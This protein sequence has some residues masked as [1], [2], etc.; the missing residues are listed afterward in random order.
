M[1]QNAGELCGIT[2]QIPNAH[3]LRGRRIRISGVFG[4]ETA[5][6]T[7]DPL[8]GISIWLKGGKQTIS[9]TVAGD[10]IAGGIGYDQL[11]FSTALDVKHVV[12]LLP[13]NA[14][15]YGTE[16]DRLN[17]WFDHIEDDGV[18]LFVEFTGHSS[19]GVVARD[20]MTMWYLDDQFSGVPATDGSF[21]LHTEVHNVDADTKYFEAYIDVP[22]DANL[23]EDDECWIVVMGVDPASVGSTVNPHRTHLYGL[24]VEVVLDS[25]SLPDRVLHG[26]LAHQMNQTPWGSG[27]LSPRQLYRYP[28][29]VPGMVALQVS[30]LV[31]AATGVGAP[32]AGNEPTIRRVLTTGSPQDLYV[33][34]DASLGVTPWY[35]IA[36]QAAL[37][38][39]SCVVKAGLPIAHKSGTGGY[40]DPRLM[41]S[42]SYIVNASGTTTYQDRTHKVVDILPGSSSA[43]LGDYVLREATSLRNRMGIFWPDTS[44]GTYSGE[45]FVDGKQGASE[46]F[47]VVE[48]DDTGDEVQL[49]TGYIYYVYDPRTIGLGGFDL[50][51]S[52]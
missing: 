26:N 46:L 41:Q 33:A 48:V 9:S 52:P 18:D 25:A 44:T 3:M 14:T 1:T 2:Q 34:I 42:N 24:A 28:F 22:D 4:T 37:P 8:G 50:S 6:A 43:P 38:P 5:P 30:S 10:W 47:F 15:A 51:G 21:E 16:H 31:A 49:S 39:G 40:S 27:G 36:P 23:F 20:A 11:K 13:G 45:P 32:V 17:R 35:Y 29:F 7:R 19:F 12:E